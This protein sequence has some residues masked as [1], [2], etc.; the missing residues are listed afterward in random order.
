MPPK[1]DD[2]EVKAPDVL[3]ALAAE[4]PT[5]KDAQIEELQQDLAE[6]R[7]ARLEERFIFI[8]VC[9]LLLDIVFFSVMPS[10]GGPIALLIL[11]LLIL[12][13]LARRMGMQEIVTMLDRVLSRIV[14][15]AND[16]GG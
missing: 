5:Q 2:A 7:D 14:G 13:P 12:I 15:K 16:G 9:V 6:E 11:Q 10:F 1:D 8:V 4:E 3:K